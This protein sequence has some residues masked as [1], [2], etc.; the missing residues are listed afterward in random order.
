MKIVR[1]LC[2]FIIVCSLAAAPAAMGQG[3]STDKGNKPA[4]AP[5]G[6]PEGSADAIYGAKPKGNAYGV[7]CRGFSK[8]HVKGTKGTPFSRCVKAMAQLDKG[9]TKSPKKACKGLATK[10]RPGQKKTD[11]ARCVSAGKALLKA[12]QS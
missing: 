12:K 3:Q 9:K 2:A 5:N 6:A 10:K 4:L 11:Y 1:T 7:R 8:K